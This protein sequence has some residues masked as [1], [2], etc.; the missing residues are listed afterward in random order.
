[1]LALRRQAAR[2]G[3]WRLRCR[4]CGAGLAGTGTRRVL[5]VGCAELRVRRGWRRLW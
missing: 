2:T 5:T 3:A 4:R 1:M